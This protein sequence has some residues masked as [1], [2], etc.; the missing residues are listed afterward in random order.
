MGYL[1][2]EAQSFD[3]SL[4]VRTDAGGSVR[5]SFRVGS[6]YEIEGR[7]RGSIIDDLF[8]I[9]VTY[10]S[11]GRDGCE[12]RIEGILAVSEAGRV[13]DGPVTIWDCGDPL[14][15]RMTFRR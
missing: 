7:V 10:A 14:S 8:R 4:D 3:A 12:S 11:A 6:P 13:V 15:G 2:V 9:T 1:S 5:G